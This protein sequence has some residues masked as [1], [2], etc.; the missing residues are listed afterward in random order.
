VLHF[1]FTE[2]QLIIVLAAVNQKILNYRSLLLSYP[3]DWNQILSLPLLLFPGKKPL[4]RIIKTLLDL[5]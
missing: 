4:S 1:P 3:L 5:S 2:K